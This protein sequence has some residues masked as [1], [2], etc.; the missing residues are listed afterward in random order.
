MAIDFLVHALGL[1]STWRVISCNICVLRL[2]IGN[3][4]LIVLA[5]KLSASL[6]F[7]VRKNVQISSHHDLFP[8]LEM[9]CRKSGSQTFPYLFLNL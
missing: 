6:P 1:A 9:L 8:E 3:E 2:H 4:Y 5:V 7:C